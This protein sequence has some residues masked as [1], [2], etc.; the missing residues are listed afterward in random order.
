MDP[1]NSPVKGQLS[2]DV[3]IKAFTSSLQFNAAVGLGTFVA[4]C[5]VRHWSKKIY[6][7]R[8]YLVSKDIRSPDL[9][10]GAFSWITAS[11][12]V[13][14]TE[15]LDKV[16]L[17]A[18]MFLRFL[19]MSAMYF[20]GCTLFSVPILIPINMI[21]GLDGDG[22]HRM[23]IG[24]V[25]TQWRLWFHL[26][27]TYIFTTGAILLLWRE[28][29]EY[30]RRRHAFLMSEKHSKTPQSTTILATAIPE[31]LNTEEALF[32]IFNRFPGGVTKIW[33]NRH[34]KSLMKMCK[35]RDKV[36][37]K[38]EMAEYNYIRSA[39]GKK[40][41]KDLE[42]KEP[43]R[44]IGKTTSV[45]CRGEKVD[46][47]EFYSDRLCQLNQ[48]I[49]QA[50]QI[51]TVD[52]LNSAFIQFRSQ[53]AAHSAVQTVVHPKP[54]RMTPM[55]SEISPLDV[56]WENMSLD[57]M[58]KKGRHM[59]ILV[60]S[61]AMILLF[62]IPT[63]A[64]SSLAS[65]AD[66]VETFPFMAFMLNLPH[67]VL[68]LIQG[69]LPPLLLAG[70]MA[71]LPVLLTMMA[72]YEGHVRHSS[73][74]LSVM[75]KYFLFLVVNVLLISTISGG[76]IKTY[77]ELLDDGFKFD[78]IISRFS[79]N[80]PAASTFFITYVLLRGFTGPALELLQVVPLLLNFLFKHLLAKSPRQI[81]DV[82][83]RLESVNYGILFPPQTLIFC[84]GTLY[85][86]MAPLI[87]PFVTFYFTMHYFVFRHQF[88]YVYLQ[89]IETGGLAFPKAAKQVYTGLFISQITL[90]GIFLMKQAELGPAVPQLVLLLILLVCTALSLSNMNEAFEPLVTFLPVALF[91]EDLHVDQDGVVTDGSE[92]VEH[93]SGRHRGED[94]EA[95][96]DNGALIRL[97]NLSKRS[98]TSEQIPTL[99]EYQPK[100]TLNKHD[101]HEDDEFAY[102]I[103]TPISNQDG[104]NSFTQSFR[105]RHPYS[106]QNSAISND[107]SQHTPQHDSVIYNE[108]KHPLNNRSPSREDSKRSLSQSGQDLPLPQ[109]NEA[110]K[111][112]DRR[113]PIPHYNSSP[114]ILV[115]PVSF[116]D[117]AGSHGHSVWNDSRPVSSVV[118]HASFGTEGVTP[119]GTGSLEEE[120]HT[121][122]AAATGF[123]ELEHLQDQ[124]YCHP[125]LYDVQQPVWLPVDER[126]LV[127]PEIDRLRRLGITV[128]TEGA[129]LNGTTAKAEVDGI[130]YAPGEETRYRLER[131]E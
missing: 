73:I 66:I 117:R 85:S 81:W 28:M 95:G 50:Q 99:Q 109:T 5:I 64:I 8:T 110:F 128:A 46:L 54:F 71:L 9:P 29:Q 23:N 121:E 107:G 39:Y 62:T 63:I 26:V 47:V 102:D 83:G 122:A 126:G 17:D 60:V 14:D 37:K 43:L 116:L 74:S 40:K 87:L 80:L 130:I 112:S 15:L 65:A 45:P 31:G 75:S 113:V 61:T 4:F 123:V 59:V 16:G 57:T 10:P 24:N 88:L 93:K 104:L 115:R 33:L 56:V 30:T 131:G 18:Y 86:A 41:K 84:I 19:R 111:R 129:T 79:Q 76:I 78:T 124:A 72:T 125:A 34:P 25:S 101:H 20:A 94:E 12:K 67:G 77:K 97:N 38:L 70:L 69:V 13:K 92:K 89:P 68:G 27:L 114:R 108:S 1:S 21:G 119:H 98:L 52:S 91:S 106:R 127:Q 32:K 36:V 105:H 44:P 35:E 2:V 53:F 6:Q 11:F 55:Y 48:Q 82:Q 3:S 58:T 51:G 100:F 49:A 103:I 90:F 7:P 42:I 22:L 120:A 96:Q 118:R